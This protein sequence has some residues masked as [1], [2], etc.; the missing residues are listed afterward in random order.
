MRLIVLVDPKTFLPVS[1]RQVDVELP[2]RPTVVESNLISYRHVLGGDAAG[3]LFDLAAQHPSAR[4]RTSTIGSSRFVRLHK[5][6][7]GD[8]RR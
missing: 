6:A 2:G 4:V 5:P 3:K 8:K 1:E 7:H